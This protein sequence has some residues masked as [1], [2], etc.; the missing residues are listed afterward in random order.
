MSS[1]SSSK[2][3]ADHHGHSSNNTEPD[4]LELIRTLRGHSINLPQTTSTSSSQVTNS[5]PYVSYAIHQL[6]DS[7]QERLPALPIAADLPMYRPPI[8]PPPSLDREGDQTD[9][10]ATDNFA[11]LNDDALL[12]R[13][14]RRTERTMPYHDTSSTDED[15]DDEPYQRYDLP[16]TLSN[17][18]SDP[19]SSQQQTD[20]VYLIPGYPGLWRPSA[21]RHETKTQVNVLSLFSLLPDLI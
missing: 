5:D 21:D 15:V 7:S 9:C 4:S 20:D 19:S 3:P 10:D 18:E 12:Q 16:R 8:A 14:Y 17:D 13:L 11:S 6:G 2:L 1:S